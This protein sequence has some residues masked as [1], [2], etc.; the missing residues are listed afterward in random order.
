[1]G[2][3]SRIFGGAKAAL[4]RSVESKVPDKLDA[5]VETAAANVSAVVHKA[6]D[7]VV[8]VVQKAN[9]F[10]QKE[11]VDLGEAAEEVEKPKAAKK[12]RKPKAK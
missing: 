5:A 10:V 8:E 1:M 11:A 3:F 12:P 6:A 7:V 4:D 2:L 9:T